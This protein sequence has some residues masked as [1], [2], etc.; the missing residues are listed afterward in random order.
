MTAIHLHVKSHVGTTYKR[1]LTRKNPRRDQVV[2]ARP[3]DL[4]ARGQAH[5]YDGCI[6]PSW[7]YDMRK[8]RDIES[9]LK[10]L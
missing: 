1:A 8:P 2:P 4:A 5:L 6:T 7:R 3:D 9:E 10:A